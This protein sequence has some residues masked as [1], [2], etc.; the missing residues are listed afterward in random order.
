[1]RADDPP[2]P[3]ARIVLPIPVRRI[4]IT[5]ASGFV[6]RHLAGAAT[7]AG[8]E[9]VRTARSAGFD[10]MTDTLPLDGVDH[11]FH[12][13]AATDPQNAWHDPVGTLQTNCVGTIR[14][15]DQCRR[16][17]CPVTLASS[18]VYGAQGSRPI[19]EDQP[20]QPANPYALS[21][22]LAEEACRG[23]AAMY[24]L[25]VAVLRIFNVYGPGQTDRFVVPH[26][27]RQVLDPTCPAVVVVDL[28]PRRDYVHIDDVVRAFAATLGFQD[29]GIFNVGTGV[30]HSVEDVIRLTCAAASVRKPWRQTGATRIAD[31]PDTVAG[32]ARIA[33]VLGWRPQ[34]DLA[35]GLRRMVTPK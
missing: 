26:I 20:A 34:V 23:F 1:M 35:E 31:V 24:D 10:L 3:A 27:V 6:G 18:Y 5:G 19:D 13:A 12:L 29:F 16:K 4:L 8:V 7:A 32:I 33:D 2:A 14:V 9:V 21:K 17:R 11:V 15:L 28:A 30:S 22:F 25:P